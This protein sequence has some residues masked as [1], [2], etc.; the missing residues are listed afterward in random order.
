MQIFIYFLFSI[1]IQ[2]SLNFKI[3]SDCLEQERVHRKEENK[4][5]FYQQKV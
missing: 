1:Y 3:G 2:K 5:D 4:N